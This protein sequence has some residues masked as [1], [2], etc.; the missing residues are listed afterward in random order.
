MSQHITMDL[1]DDTLLMVAK[2]ITQ[3]SNENV[4]V[5]PQLFSRQVTG[6]FQ[7]IPVE[8]AL[9]KLAFTNGIKLNKTTDNVYVLEPLREGEE[10]VTKPAK[11]PS[12]NFSIKR[13]IN[14][15]AGKSSPNTISIEQNENG[16]KLINLNVTNAPINDLIRD[17]AEQAG[18]NYF[19]YSDITGTATANVQSMAFDDVLRFILQSTKYTFSEE[20][21]VYM[22]GERNVEGLRKQKL[23]HLQ[24]RSVD[25]LLVVIP[26]QI[27][28]HVDI[29]EFKELNSFLLS[30]SEP[31]IK[32]IEAFVGQLDKTVPMVTIEVILMDVKK[33][34]TVETGIKLGVSDSISTGGTILGGLDYTFS[35]KDINRFIDRIGLNN[36]FNLGRVTPNFYASLKAIESNGNVE[37]RQTPKLSTLNGH[38]ANL[39]IGSTRY[40]AA[41]TQNVM[42]SLNPQ[43]IVTQQFFP[44][45]ANLSIEIKPFVSGEEQVTLNIDVN[46]TDFIG[47]VTINAPPPSSTSKFRSIIRVKNEEMIVL[48]GIERNEKSDE[49][50]GVPF[51]SRIPV[52]KWLFSSRS[53]TTSKVVS[54]VFI[55]PT[56]FY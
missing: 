25:S 56:I 29:K 50:S 9:E 51:L 22:I 38:A 55:K 11:K 49:G 4:V 40:Y 1:R 28:Q 16:R 24:H 32:E 13:N 34:K 23:I 10:I 36:V 17:I 54:V 6:Y 42:G 14:R 52:L 21:G 45:E 20:K 44:V 31:E 53:R 30:G 43:T 18:I 39:S 41:Q 26:Q 5:V 2:K 15:Q 48:G 7:D 46:I 37:L 47:N 12:P 3:L 8:N 35:S 19:I 27:K 33:S